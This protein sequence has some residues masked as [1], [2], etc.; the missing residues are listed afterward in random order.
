METNKCINHINWIN[1]ALKEENKL[2][3]QE[4]KIRKQERPFLLNRT[5]QTYSQSFLVYFKLHMTFEKGFN[6]SINSI[7]INKKG[8]ISL[9]EIYLKRIKYFYQKA[10]S[11]I[12]VSKTEINVPY[13]LMESQMVKLKS[14]NKLINKL[15]F[16]LDYLIKHL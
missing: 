7:P 16:S 15:E 9:N 11:E 4:L 3:L 14:I 5:Y 2:L 6:L 10:F 13:Q 1:N 12:N 8:L